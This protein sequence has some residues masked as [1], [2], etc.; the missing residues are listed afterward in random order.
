MKMNAL[1]CRILTTTCMHMH[2]SCACKAWLTVYSYAYSTS[3]VLSYNIIATYPAAVHLNN[4]MVMDGT[5]QVSSESVH[6]VYEYRPL[7]INFLFPV[8]RPHPFLA[9]HEIFHY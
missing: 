7:Q 8:H 3:G 9:C 5:V 6:M 4:I 2:D 1:E